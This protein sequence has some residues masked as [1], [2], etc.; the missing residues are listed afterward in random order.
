MTS[1]PRI[2]SVRFETQRIAGMD[3]GGAREVHVTWEG[4]GDHEELLFSYYPDEITVT[5]RELIGMTKAEAAKLFYDKDIAY[6][7]SP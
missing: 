2:A 5:G 6:L 4:D 3:L 1:E 7:R